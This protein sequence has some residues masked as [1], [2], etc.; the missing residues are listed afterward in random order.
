[1]RGKDTLDKWA[2]LLLD[3]GKRNNLINFRD[4]RNS[5]AEI[6]LPSPFTLFDKMSKGN[7]V[8]EVYD[9][10]LAEQD[11]LIEDTPNSQTQFQESD[12]Q[13]AKDAYLARYSP[14]LKKRSQLLLYNHSAATPIKAVR[15]INK[16]AREFIE[17]TGVN[18]AY[19]A[20][21]FVHWKEKVLSGEEFRAPVLLVPIQLVHDSVVDPYYIKTTEDD[22]IVNPTFVYKLDV[23][24]GIKL[25]DY[26]E[27]SLKEYLDKISKLVEKLQWTVSSECKLS[28]FS[29]LKINMYRDLKDNAPTS[30]CNENVRRLLGETVKENSVNG[31]GGKKRSMTDPLTDLYCVVD[32]DSSQIAAI[33]TAKSGKSFVLQGPPGTGKSQTITNIIAECLGEGKKVL[34]VSEKLAALNVVYDKLKQAG[35][36]EFCLELHSHKA[37][38]KNVINEICH[39][40]RTAKSSVSSKADQEI[41]IKEKAR[42][43]LDKYVDELHQQRPVLEKSL[44]Q[45]YEAFSS[46]SEAPDMEWVIPNITDKSEGYLS[47]TVLL[48]EEYADFVLDTIIKRIHGMDI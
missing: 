39:T 36:A 6:L 46:I 5:T 30:L 17:E 21:G 16:R 37:N 31:K 13:N 32:A 41:A 15:N 18:V 28:I 11:Y 3:T 8:L 29:F 22:V 26:D 35:L 24:Y 9:P 4:T 23:E 40:L 7:I 27:E 25:P 1:M 2:D 19:M 42:K 10:K 20:F 43:R 33:E 47:E 12:I 45:M 38:K 44:Y 34:F 14:K 48:L